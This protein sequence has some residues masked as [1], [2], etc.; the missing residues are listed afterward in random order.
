MCPVIKIRSNYILY[1]YY[2]V[3][4][5]KQNVIFK[6]FANVLYLFI[7]IELSK[8]LMVEFNKHCFQTT[9]DQIMINN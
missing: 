9:L 2:V 1:L 6:L 5:H 4:F 7:F 8:L 3:F